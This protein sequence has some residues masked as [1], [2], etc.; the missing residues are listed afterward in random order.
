MRLLSTLAL[1]SLVVA[2]S[3]A[4]PDQTPALAAD[5]LCSISL[6]FS[7][8]V[9]AAGFRGATYVIGP[10]CTLRQI[11]SLP[12]LAPPSE[13]KASATGA[14][15]QRATVAV[16]GVSTGVSLV[17]WWIRSP[18]LLAGNAAGENNPQMSTSW[19]W[20]GTS[21]VGDAYV[22]EMA[23]RAHNGWVVTT[24]T[25]EWLSFSSTGANTHAHW[26]YD[27]S[28]DGYHMTYDSYSAIS[29][30]GTTSCSGVA[31]GTVPA[32]WTLSFWC[33]GTTQGTYQG[34]F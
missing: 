13:S 33:F 31:S 3:E 21:I 11:D 15:S 2:T 12:P 18:L 28:S 30:T 9:P 27:K 25:S 24:H 19:S 26:Q 10:D 22:T 8:P 1:I 5:R 17:Y 7:S 34:V 32:S 23:E 6:T 14:N 16:N 29:P 4:L 20:D